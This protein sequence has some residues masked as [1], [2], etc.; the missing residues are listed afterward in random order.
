MSN[1]TK[2]V[3][4]AGVVALVAPGAAQA[5]TKTV[6]MGTPPSS[7][8]AFQQSGSDVNDFFP[9]GITVHVGDSVKF[10]PVGFHTIDFP[11]KGGLAQPLFT[12]SGKISGENDAAGQAFWFNGQDQFGFTPAL[13]T[14]GYGKKFTYNG[15]K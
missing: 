10:L 4:V 2:A 5:A 7:Q 9:H 15:S 11:P 13:L 14:P 3:L 8:K 6:N 12:A 1:R